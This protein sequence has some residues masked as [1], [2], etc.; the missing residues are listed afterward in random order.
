V[1][2][3]PAGLADLKGTSV[4]LRLGVLVSLLK[5]QMCIFI[6]DRWVASLSVRT[7]GHPL[8]NGAEWKCRESRESGTEGLT[9]VANNST[10]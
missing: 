8:W 9:V 7:Y 6:Q 10:H 2:W 5:I 1:P 3:E 4:R